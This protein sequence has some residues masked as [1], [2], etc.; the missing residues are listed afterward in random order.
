M[1]SPIHSVDS[2]LDASDDVLQ[3]SNGTNPTAHETTEDRADDEH[4]SDGK[5]RKES[6]LQ[7]NRNGIH[8][9]S[10]LSL[11]LYARDDRQDD[12]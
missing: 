4:Y 9:A 11:R 1:C 8:R 12:P 7:E 10:D 3:K 2:T 6:V 5:P